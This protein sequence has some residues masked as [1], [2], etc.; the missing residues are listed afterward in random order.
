MLAYLEKNKPNKNHD[1]REAIEQALRAIQEK[2]YDYKVEEDGNY[3][4]HM[5]GQRRLAKRAAEEA[6]AQAA[7]LNGGR[8]HSFAQQI[9]QQNYNEGIAKIGDIIPSLQKQ[10]REAYDAGQKQALSE[11]DKLLNLETLAQREYEQA[12]AKWQADRAYYY[13]KQ[14]DERKRAEAAALLASRQSTGGGGRAT[15]K[16]PKALTGLKS[17]MQGIAK[18]K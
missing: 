8:L 5:A 17:L 14:E 15:K 1:Y 11:V 16:V 6:L 10:A 9:A 18:R 12:L 2:K 3:Q 13:K 4:H 7:A